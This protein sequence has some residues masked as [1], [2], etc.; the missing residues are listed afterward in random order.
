MLDGMEDPT[1]GR[2]KRYIHHY[3]MPGYS[4]GEVA[5]FA[6]PGAAKLVM[7]CSPNAR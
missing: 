5:P 7:A 6:V 3:N 2:A 4:V 1:D